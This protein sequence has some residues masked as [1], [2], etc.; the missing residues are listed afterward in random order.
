MNNNTV[1]LMNITSVNHVEIMLKNLQTEVLNGFPIY[2]KKDFAILETLLTEFDQP[3]DYTIT[4][5]PQNQLFEI[6]QLTSDIMA[7]FASDKAVNLAKDLKF[8]AD[9]AIN[10]VNS[11]L[12]M[13]C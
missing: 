1:T 6:S 12:M 11:Q 9:T 13:A 7:S 2:S 3:R 4:N 10:F 8:L 5:I